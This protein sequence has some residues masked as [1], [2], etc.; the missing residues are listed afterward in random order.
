M[1]AP[2]GSPTLRLGPL[3][4]FH[5]GKPRRRM[6]SAPRSFPRCKDGMCGS[7]PGCLA[8]MAAS[9]RPV[10]GTDDEHP[11]A[12][13]AHDPAA[14]SGAGL[15]PPRWRPGPTGPGPA[16][17]GRRARRPAPPAFLAQGFAAAGLRGRPAMC[18]IPG[19]GA[20][21]RIPPMR[22]PGLQR[23]LEPGAPE[24]VAAT[25]LKPSSRRG[26]MQDAR[27]LQR[28]AAEIEVLPYQDRGRVTPVTRSARVSPHPSDR[29]KHL[30]K[31]LTQVGPRFTKVS[32]RFCPA[33]ARRRSRVAAR[34]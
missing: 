10:L 16:G 23:S 8:T 29:F 6:G 4:Y 28:P 17:A 21:R 5:Y 2:W 13:A 1:G 7:G 34:P 15:R 9:L 33:A 30:L 11:D 19:S 3:R 12:V 31:T 26:T 27:S 18:R 32:V 22:R 20:E 24:P 14:G 25:E